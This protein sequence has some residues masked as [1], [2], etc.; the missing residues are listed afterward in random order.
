M[1]FSISVWLKTGLPSRGMKTA[2]LLAPIG[3]VVLFMSGLFYSTGY[4]MISSSLAKDPIRHELACITQG[5]LAP[6]FR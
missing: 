4:A 5:F 6:L 2:H 1:F 3:S